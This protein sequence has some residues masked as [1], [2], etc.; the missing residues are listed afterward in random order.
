MCV[1][2]E[3][4]DK[5]QRRVI[6][7]EGASRFRNPAADLP[8]DFADQQAIYYDELGQSLDPDAFIRRE[9]Q[10]LRDALKLLHENIPSNEKVRFNQR[11]G[12]SWILVSPLEAQVEPKNLTG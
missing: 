8:Q 7:V 6:W 12:K 4:R 9:K 10:A 1:L 11:G 5:L 2:Q 3:L